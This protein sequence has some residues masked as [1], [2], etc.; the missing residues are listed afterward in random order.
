DNLINEEI[1]KTKF[2]VSYK[3]Y[4]MD[5]YFEQV[6]SD[7]QKSLRIK[8]INDLELSIKRRRS[9]LENVNYVKNAPKEIVEKEKISLKEELEKFDV[10]RKNN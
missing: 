10:L 6:L 2:K 4:E 1:N 5:I 7:E 8:A 9:L 3:E